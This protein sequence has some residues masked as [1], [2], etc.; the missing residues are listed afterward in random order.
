MTAYMNFVVDVK[1]TTFSTHNAAKI[2]AK[3]D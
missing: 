2:E 3:A 1:Q